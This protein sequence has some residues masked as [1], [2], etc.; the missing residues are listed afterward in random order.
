V[1]SSCVTRGSGTSAAAQALGVSVR[2]VQAMIKQ[3]TLRAE[4]VGRDWLI[5]EVEIERARQQA[6]PPGRPRK[7]DA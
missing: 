3:G 4:K 6:R 2:R 7:K 5:D 1:A